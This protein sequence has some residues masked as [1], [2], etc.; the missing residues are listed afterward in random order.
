LPRTGRQIVV[1]IR[2]V[3]KSFGSVHAVNDLSLDIKEGEFV[4]LL[5]PNGAGKTTLLEMIEGLQTPDSGG[6]EI[7][8]LNY[9]QHA[10]Q[11][12]QIMGLAFQETRFPERIRVIEALRLFA[13]FYGVPSARTAEILDLVSLKEKKNAYVNTL[14]G[15]QRQRLALGIAIIQK[16]RLLLLDEP[17]TGL[18]PHA[19][20][21]LWQI[22]SDLKRAG[23]TLLLT[24]HYMEEAEELCERIVILF[25]GRILADG[26]LKSL[27]KEHASHEIIEFRLNKVQA[28]QLA[29]LRQ[30]KKVSY[31]YIDEQTG[32]GVMH[33][34][35]AATVL[36]DF[37]RRVGRHNLESFAARPLTLDDLFIKMTGRHLQ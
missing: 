16:P 22:L 33:V 14:S 26:S 27:L 25:R 6:I 31:I 9:S 23:M 8:G 37:M 18:D 3:C 1:A 24:T 5:G 19:R 11:I 12:R 30:M 2:N 10:R 29:G 17:T 35:H 7:C 20:R 4:A 36:P 28:R 21:E 15:G 13:A 34:D 32:S